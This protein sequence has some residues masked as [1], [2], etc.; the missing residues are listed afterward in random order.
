MPYR[1]GNYDFVID[2]SFRPFSFQ[3]MLAPYAIYKDAFEK[4]EE[5]YNELRTKADDFKYLSETLPEG[6]RAREIYEQYANDLN[7]QTL[8]FAQNGLTMGNRSALT[9]LRQRY[10][11]EIG[12]LQKIDEIRRAQIKEQ[13]ALRLQDPTRL[14]SRRADM[15]PFDDYLD[16]PDLGYESYSGALLAKQVNDAASALAK[17]LQESIT[18][19]NLD[20]YT[21]KWIEKRGFSAG[22]VLKAIQ[23]PESDRTGVLSSIVEDAIQGSGIKNWADANTLKDAYRIASQGLWGAVGQS[24]IHTYEDYGARLRAQENKEKSILDYKADLIRKQQEDLLRQQ[25]QRTTSAVIN[26]S[27]IGSA[28]EAVEQNQNIKNYSKYF[29]TDAKG[30][31]YLNAEG[32]KAY[33]NKVSVTKGTPTVTSEGTTILTDAHVEYQDS[34]F[35]Q[36]I[37]SIGGSKYFINGKPQPGNIGNLWNQYKG[38]DFLKYD[39]TALTEYNHNIDPS[40]Y[41]NWKARIQE[42]AQGELEKVRWDKKNKKWV[43]SGKVSVK[44]AFKNDGNPVSTQSSSYGRTFRITD[45]DGNTERYRLPRGIN[46]RAEQNIDMHLAAL[47]TVQSLYSKLDSNGSKTLTAEEA[48]ELNKATGTRVFNAGTVVNLATLQAVNT[49]LEDALATFESQ[50]GIT[51]TNKPQEWSPIS[52]GSSMPAPT[53]SL[54]DDEE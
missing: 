53:I 37:D 27:N 35:K 50:L 34:P 1:R 44:E 16:N 42:R 39:A 4:S 2:S 15:T 45:K 24:Q 22:E 21:K 10:Q 26:P 40:E 41:S 33:N 49:A 20:E 28:E 5:A 11:G 46:T 38:Q 3:E 54:D 30:R 32:I 31:T 8:D 17:G 52:F 29:T 51:N 36:F 43:S 6:S 14:F 7:T 47:S 19:G 12:R 23:H 18:S 48:R 25:Q 13:N 9:G